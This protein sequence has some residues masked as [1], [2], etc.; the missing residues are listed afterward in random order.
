VPMGD[1]CCCPFASSI[2]IASAA[3]AAAAIRHHRL[4]GGCV[5]GGGG[6]W[7]CVVDDS[8]IMGTG[9]GFCKTELVHLDIVTM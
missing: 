5:W 6:R 2:I 4:M 3:A 7:H 9:K 8:C 1:G